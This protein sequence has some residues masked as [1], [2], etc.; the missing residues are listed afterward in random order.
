MALSIIWISSVSGLISMAASRYHQGGGVTQSSNIMISLTMQQ[1]GL[2][3]AYAFTAGNQARISL[4]ALGRELLADPRVTAL[5]LHIEGIGDMADFEQLARFADKQGKPV[6]ALKVGR[7]AQ[8]QA[9]QFHIPP[10]L[11]EVMRRLT[12]C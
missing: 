6:V 7:S 5:G 2:P 11:P 3:V 1:R 8:A 12:R 9:T 4:S 10:L